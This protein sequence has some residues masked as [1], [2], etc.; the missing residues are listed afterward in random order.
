MDRNR[1]QK[2]N[3]RAQGGCYTAVSREEIHGGAVMRY[4]D[5]NAV[6]DNMHALRREDMP[7]LR[8]G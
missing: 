4:K 1:K 3:I 6:L 5:G 7:S 2:K 8:L